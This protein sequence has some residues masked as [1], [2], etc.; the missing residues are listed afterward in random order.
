MWEDLFL[1]DF[2]AQVTLL[3]LTVIGSSA[4]P[5]TQL[6]ENCLLLT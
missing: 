3:R 2:E 4:F 6:H 1:S 5:S